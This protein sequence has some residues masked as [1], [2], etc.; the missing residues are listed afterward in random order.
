MDAIAHKNPKNTRAAHKNRLQ[1]NMT[2]ETIAYLDKFFEPYN[3]KLAELLGDDRFL[4]KDYRNKTK[5]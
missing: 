4:W 5:S 2:P 3:K 1:D